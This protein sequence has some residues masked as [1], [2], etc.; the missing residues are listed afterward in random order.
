[1][2]D[3][4]FELAPDLSPGA[5]RVNLLIICLVEDAT[6]KFERV[7][8]EQSTV[9]GAQKLQLTFPTVQLACHD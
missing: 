6:V 8:L 1:M 5:F 9:N 3:L 2:P 4:V 7:V